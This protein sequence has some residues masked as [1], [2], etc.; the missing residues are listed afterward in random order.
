M[1][2]PE[3]FQRGPKYGKKSKKLPK[4][5]TKPLLRKSTK[6]RPQRRRK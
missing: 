5:P 6:K 4:K 1:N 2:I 3:V